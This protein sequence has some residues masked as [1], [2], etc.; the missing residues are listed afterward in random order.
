MLTFLRPRPTLTE[1]EIQSSLRLIAWEGLSSGA[2]F[3]LGSG[4]F[5]AAYALAL[6]VNNLQVGMLASL[7]F[8]S[9]VVRLPAILLVERFRARKALGLPALAASQLSWL[10]VGLVPLLLDTP[11][12]L[13]VFLVIVFLAMRGLFAPVWV[14]TSTSWARDLVP[15]GS[16]GSYFSRRL[17]LVKTGEEPERTSG[18][19]AILLA[20]LL[21]E[22]LLDRPPQCGDE[23]DLAAEARRPFIKDGRTYIVAKDFRSWLERTK[24]IKADQVYQRLRQCG[25]QPRAVN[26]PVRHGRPK[27]TSISAWILPDTHPHRGREGRHP[28]E[29]SEALS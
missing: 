25:T 28:E 8:I 14:T 20:A 27:R 24:G 13:A 5:M 29:E 18:V 4:G 21:E 22:Y 15:A 19:Q 9:Q 2:M 17:A 26:L 6:G 11:G 3:S 12:K 10:P 16:L 23:W 1:R 7:P